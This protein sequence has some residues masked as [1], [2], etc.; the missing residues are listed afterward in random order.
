M[1]LSDKTS[2]GVKNQKPMDLFLPSKQNDQHFSAIG[3][4]LLKNKLVQVQV[5]KYK[6]VHTF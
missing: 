5:I 4:I 6:L 2:H 3:K 1:F